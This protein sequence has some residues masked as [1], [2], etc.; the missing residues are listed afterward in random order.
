MTSTDQTP[1]LSAHAANWYATTGARFANVRRNT[2]ETG[3]AFQ[4]MHQALMKPGAL[5]ALEK[6]LIALGI[7]LAV[8]CESCI[9]AH[10]KACRRL[11]A[12][13]EQ[14]LEVIGVATLMGG[15]PVWS[16]APLVVEALDAL[17]ALDGAA[18][19]AS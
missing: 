4:A 14:I 12:T 15:G 19:A 5:S 2:P 9:F 1:S 17:D 11:G 16:H 18:D 6:E 8:R 7:G 13:R 10:V 3:Q